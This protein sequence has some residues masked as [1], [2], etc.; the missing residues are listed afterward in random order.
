MSMVA[1]T[2]ERIGALVQEKDTRR[3]NVAA[4][5]AREQMWLFHS[6]TSN[7]LSNSC[8]RKRLLK[9]FYDT[10]VRKVAGIS[11]E[12][13]RRAAHVADRWREESPA[14]FDSWFEVDVALQIADRGYT[15]VPQFEFAGKRI[16]LVVQ[17]GS[18]QLAVEC[19]GDHWH[20]RDQFED[21]MQR[22]RMLERCNWIFFRVRESNYRIDN[23]KALEQ[24][25]GMLE[26]RGIYPQGDEQHTDSPNEAAEE[27]I[28]D[29]AEPNSHD[30]NDVDMELEDEDEINES[31]EVIEGCPL[32]IQ[33]ALNFKPAEL[34][35]LILEA[36]KKLPNS[37]C[38]RKALTTI[39]LRK[40]RIL[41][42][43]APR[44][45]FERKVE[46]QVAA[47]IRDGHLIA[48]RSKNERL[49]LGWNFAANG[50]G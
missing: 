35:K 24:L 29:S 36:M 50:Q 25:W 49:K 16:D 14:P 27:P 37:S 21:D 9:H 31:D 12:D 23:E 8:L 6:V 17:G 39:I 41:T 3:F 4:S 46:Y 47:M 13:L 15:V 26:A 20:G 5:R 38:V 33:E 42:R 11:V 48:Y 43:G 1:A 22:Q 45:A 34:R 40:C 10:T 7:D 44:K 30:I 28:N 18:A 2:N 19:D 32:S